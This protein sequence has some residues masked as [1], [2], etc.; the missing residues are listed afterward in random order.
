MVAPPSTDAGGPTAA[1]ASYLATRLSQNALDDRSS[2][3]FSTRARGPERLM[4]RYNIVSP[5]GRRVC[6][7][8]QMAWPMR[9]AWKGV[10]RPVDRQWGA[11]WHPRGFPAHACLDRDL[12]LP[13]FR[14]Q[15]CPLRGLIVGCWSD[16]KEARL[17]SAILCV[18]PRPWCRRVI[19]LSTGMA[20]ATF[21]QAR[22]RDAR[23]P[24]HL[25]AG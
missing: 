3:Y 22:V 25:H 10:K 7:G 23:L 8:H 11:A 24:D 16:R 19:R 17:L 2:R 14:Q 5:S 4:P 20:G 1:R 15:T 6:T 12:R 9:H 13:P 18:Y 21:M